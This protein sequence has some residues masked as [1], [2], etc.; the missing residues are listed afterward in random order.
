[1]TSSSLNI[2]LVEDNQDDATLFR[3]AVSKADV[4]IKLLI[5][6]DGEKAIAYLKGEGDYGD[7]AVYPIPD[8][9]LLDLNMPRK[10]GFEVLEWI[11]QHPTY[12]QLIVHVLTA[13]TREMD[14]RH[15]YELRANSYVVKPSR[16]NELT[17]FIQALAAWHQFVHLPIPV[18]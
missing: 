15:A 11:R 16:V 10:N 9:V 13:S 3:M 1:M 5:V 12:K 4:P 2:L 14:V 6:L 18:L 17:A 7:R 8:L